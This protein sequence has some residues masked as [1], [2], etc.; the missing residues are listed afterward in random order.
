MIAVSSSSGSLIKVLGVPSSGQDAVVYGIHPVFGLILESTLNA[1]IWN[2]RR[3]GIK[4]PEVAW[5]CR[6]S[7][8]A[9]GALKAVHGCEVKSASAGEWLIL[10][11]AG[12][13][14][15]VT[16][17]AAADPILLQA[18][19]K[20]K[21]RDLAIAVSAALSI[22]LLFILFPKNAAEPEQPQVVE[23]VTVE[24]KPEVQKT[25]AIP[26]VT[27]PD[28]PQ[29]RP[30][31]Q[32]TKQQVKRAIQK[33]LGFLSLLGQKDMKKVL[34][35]VHQELKEATAGA[36]AGGK[37]GSGGEVLEGLG[38]GLKRVTVGNTGTKGLGGVGT[39]GAGGGQGGYGNSQ[40]GSGEG[41]ALSSVPL[42]EDMVLEGGLS[43]SAIQ[44]T[45]AKYLSQVRACYER[46]LKNAPG[47][48]GTVNMYFEIAG[49]GT[50]STT[51]VRNSTLDDAKV[52]ECIGNSMLGW[53]FPHP[54]GGVKVKV[55]YPFLL[56]PMGS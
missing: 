26:Q 14:Y 47:L 42:S 36:G 13:E 48:S 53:Q 4:T 37:E 28:A 35:G 30:K 22:L 11:A 51:K 50:V 33:D 18:K 25:V 43:K 19:P 56:R 46:A 45:I 29:T 9:G 54:V 40:V 15:R 24:I 55:N 34:G 8:A 10:T 52:G 3:R 44:A 20:E 23:Q 2:R 49:D 6:F 21:E 38:E 32:E 16:A 39:K 12:G 7:V 17:A 31:D 5:T 27:F 1:R 41:K